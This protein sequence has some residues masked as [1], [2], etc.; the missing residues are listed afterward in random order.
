MTPV[1]GVQDPT[2]LCQANGILNVGEKT[3]IYHGRWCN[4]TITKDNYYAEVALAT[5]PRDRWGSLALAK[6]VSAG[7][8]WSAPITLAEGGCGIALN[9]E[10]GGLMSVEL[11]DEDG[12]LLP[13]YSGKNMAIIRGEKGLEHALKWPGGDLLDLGGTTVRLKLGLRGENARLYAVYLVGK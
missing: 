11:A 2:I 8:I 12:S 4:A 10:D 13:A 1:P 5:L 3:L 7:T 6:G 9:A